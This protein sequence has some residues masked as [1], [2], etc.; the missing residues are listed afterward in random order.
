MDYTTLSREGWTGLR[1]RAF[2]DSTDGGS[3]SA[4]TKGATGP[5]IPP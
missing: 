3:G 5:V 2:E 4:A 1:S